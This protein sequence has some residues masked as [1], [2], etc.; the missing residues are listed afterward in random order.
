MFLNRGAHY[1]HPKT[2]KNSWC[3]GPT[4]VQ[5]IRISGGR[6]HHIYTFFLTKAFQVIPSSVQPG[7]RTTGGLGTCKLVFKV[8]WI[9][10]QRCCDTGI[11]DILGFQNG[12]KSWCNLENTPPR[13]QTV[14]GV[15]DSQVVKEMWILPSESSHVPISCTKSGGGF[16]ICIVVESHDDRTL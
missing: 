2:L 13:G 7:L 6:I 14:L 9:R 4:P 11:F 12:R 5:L 8:Y 15:R 3:H 16:V 1:K 10:W